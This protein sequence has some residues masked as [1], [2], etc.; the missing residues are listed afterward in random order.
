MFDFLQNAILRN[1]APVIVRYALVA[2]GTFLA[3]KGLDANIVAWL[4][5][6][7][8]VASIVGIFMAM[9]AA[10]W[11][12][13]KRPSAAGME[14]A[15]AV[16]NGVEAEIVTPP[17]KPDMVVRPKAVAVKKNFKSR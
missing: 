3:S 10:V 2:I 14:A 1:Y 5:S 4:T 16:D 6:D 15:K 11:G 7:T 9:G 13:V 12:L 8:T 17:G